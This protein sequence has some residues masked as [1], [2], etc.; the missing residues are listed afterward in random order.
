MYSEVGGIK[1]ASKAPLPLSGD[2]VIGVFVPSLRIIFAVMVFLITRSFPVI[3]IS[4]L[5]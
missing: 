5:F 3:L 2:K 1:V 4:M